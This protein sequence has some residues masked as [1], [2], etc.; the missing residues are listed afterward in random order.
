MNY[1]YKIMDYSEKGPKTLF[2]ANNGSKVIPMN[3]WIE[4][5]KHKMVSDGSS[6][7]KYMSGWHVFKS[8]EEAKE[9]LYKGF[10]NICGKLIVKCH[11]KEDIRKKEHSR[12]NIWLAQQLYLI[13][14]VFHQ[15]DGY[16]KNS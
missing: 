9:Y 16:R 12:A 3:E 1:Y 10:K 15:M 11:V 8:Y 13:D 6:N 14:V 4:A 7:T 5:S 2:H